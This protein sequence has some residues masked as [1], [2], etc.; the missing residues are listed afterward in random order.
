VLCHC[1]IDYKLTLCP[2]L[3]PV[4]NISYSL[5]Y[6]ISLNFSRSNLS[7]SL[8]RKTYKKDGLLLGHKR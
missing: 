6:E 4:L 1:E 2:E 8:L 5:E 7:G 3:G